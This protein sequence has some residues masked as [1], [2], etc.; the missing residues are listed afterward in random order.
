[1]SISPTAEGFR[2]A[3]R[4]PLFTLG[5]I[6]WR[7]VTGATATALFF[8]GFFEYLRSLPVTNGELLLLRSRQPYV[9]SQVLAHILRGSL[10]RVV[11][12]A[13]LAAML[14]ALLWMVAGSI[15]R[16]ATVRAMLDYLRERFAP[17]LASRE[18]KTEAAS[19]VFA[20]PLPALFRLNFL[21]V[22]V[23]LAAILGFVGAAILAG[24]ASPQSHPRPGLAF[25][26]FVPIAGLISIAWSGLNWLLSLAG[27]FAARDGE[28]AVGA[29]AAA[30]AL[31][32]E[33]TGAV[34]A[35]SSWFGL[36]HIV[37]FVGAFTVVSM[38]LGFAP[39]LPGRLILAAMILIVLV[40][41]AVVDWLYTARLAGYLCIA[42]LPGALLRPLPPPPPPMPAIPPPALQTPLQTT[43][44]R[45]ELILSDVSAPAPKPQTT[46][47]RDEPILSNIP[48]PPGA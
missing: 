25:F 13:L 11:M 34:A 9:V 26:L 30:V 29:I 16:I 21:R 27:M 22:T 35:V 3:Y 38:P 6:T 15:G 12:S 43:I 32:R 47:D 48:N 20:S 2:A 36:A 10:S 7:W 44:D 39:I 24:F 33:R 4:R 28:D 19:T 31:C 42:E 1:M 23:A 8:F 46:I 18:G 45:D 41:F 37:V 17:L 14:L 40:Y 5:E